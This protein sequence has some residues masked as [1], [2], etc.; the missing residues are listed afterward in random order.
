VHYRKQLDLTD[1]ALAGAREGSRRLGEFQNRLLAAAGD[2]DSPAFL[3]AADRLVR[4]LAEALDDDLNAP[5]AVAALFAFASAGNAALDAGEAAG[6]RALAAWRRADGVLAVV[7]AVASKM[8][9]ASATLVGGS[10]VA[11]EPTVTEA[12]PEDA[13]AGE[14]ERV[15][16]AERWAAIRLAH[17]SQRNFAEADRIRTVLRRGGFEVR[18]RK[19][20]KV[21]VVRL[22]TP[23]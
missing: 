16:W 13:P 1:E 4:E 21:Q 8:V 9:E 20:G 23:D 17:K 7:S 18:D 22:T 14:S 11:A 5:R 6:P 3:D 19:D 12:L 2:S 10:Q 15:A